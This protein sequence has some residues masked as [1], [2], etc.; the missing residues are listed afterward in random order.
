MRV[1][2][3]F[4][5][6]TWIFLFCCCPERCATANRPGP[7]HRRSLWHQ[8][9]IPRLPAGQ[10]LPC[11]NARP[12]GGKGAQ[13]LQGG[14]SPPPALHPSDLM[15]GQGGEESAQRSRA[16]W[17]RVE[18][19]MTSLWRC[20]ARSLF[21]HKQPCSYSPY[22]CVLLPCLFWSRIH[23]THRL[24]VFTVCLESFEQILG[25]RGTSCLL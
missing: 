18:S 13:P 3:Y 23:L 14:T 8:D 24:C 5:P 1:V 25:L 21:F 22:C 20:L 19:R 12:G 9:Q 15:G 17:V 11:P 4:L 7:G 2:S 16:L 10:T 6:S